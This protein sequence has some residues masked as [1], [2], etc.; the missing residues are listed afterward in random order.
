M[1]FPF[2]ETF[3]QL[4]GN[5]PFP[6]QCA[7][8]K[9]FIESDFPDACNLPTGLGKTNVIAVWLIALLNEPSKLPRRFSGYNVSFNVSVVTWT[10][11]V[12]ADSRETIQKATLQWVHRQ[13]GALILYRA[14]RF[15]LVCSLRI[16]WYHV[17]CL[18]NSV[19]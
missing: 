10:T 7:L 4:T 12:R 16:V 5:A 14:G 17:R 18:M 13:M 15:R 3:R 11:V 9:R 8:Y 6:W 2:P 19:L 1:Q